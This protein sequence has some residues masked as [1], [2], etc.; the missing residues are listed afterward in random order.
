V[1]HFFKRINGYSTA[2][3]FGSRQLQFLNSSARTKDLGGTR[4]GAVHLSNDL[5]DGSLDPFCHVTV[6]LAGQFR[7]LMLKM[8]E[9]LLLLR[10]GVRPLLGV[11]PIW[12]TVSLRSFLT[13]FLH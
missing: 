6:K 5:R 3:R 11:D 8:K 9:V 12:W 10:Y 1:Q 4:I 7:E 13:S 2:S